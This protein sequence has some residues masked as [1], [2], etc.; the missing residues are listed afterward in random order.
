MH[1]CVIRRSVSHIPIHFIYTLHIHTYPYTYKYTYTYTYTFTYTCIYTNTYLEVHKMR[2]R[3]VLGIAYKIGGSLVREQGR[4]CWGLICVET[5]K[6]LDSPQLF[7]ELLG[8]PSPVC[9][10]DQ[11]MYP[12]VFVRL[13]KRTTL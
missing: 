7:L 10:R 4:G 1:G 11:F 9:L 12:Q 3:L 2:G 8:L 6:N 5:V 13:F